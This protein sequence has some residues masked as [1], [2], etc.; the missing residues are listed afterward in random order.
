M[1]RKIRKKNQIPR[2]HV[3]SPKGTIRKIQDRLMKN[4]LTQW[5]T[6]EENRKILSVFGE[7]PPNPGRRQ[8][9]KTG[10]DQVEERSKTFLLAWWW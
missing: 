10:K 7:K 5:D 9:R 4:L 2:Y 1:S 6:E 8:K 3:L